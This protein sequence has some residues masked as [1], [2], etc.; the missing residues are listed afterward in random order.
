M[1][2][3]DENKNELYCTDAYV[4]EP[5]KIIKQLGKEKK[6]GKRRNEKGMKKEGKE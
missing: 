3:P 4:A 6:E 2:F 1:A 5:I